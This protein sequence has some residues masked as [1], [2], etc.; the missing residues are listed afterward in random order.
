MSGYTIK[1]EELSY[2]ISLAAPEVKLA[3]SRTGGQGS[4]GDSITSAATVNGEL[5]FTVTRADGTTF[6]INAGPLQVTTALDGLIDVDNVNESDGDVIIYDSAAQKWGNH[7]LTTSKFA[8]VDNTNKEDGAI[9]V[10][11]DTSQKYQSTNRIEK[12]T[13]YIIGGNF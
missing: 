11:D 3:L 7:Q 4:K 10:Y 8:D 2:D 5:I 12:G 9:L 1:M 13:T 6:E